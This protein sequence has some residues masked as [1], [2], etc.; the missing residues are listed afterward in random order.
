MINLLLHQSTNS[1]VFA[2]A[3]RESMKAG[4]LKEI[5]KNDTLLNVTKNGE[6][7]ADKILSIACP[8]ECSGHG[9]CKKGII[10]KFLFSDITAEYSVI[11]LKKFQFRKQL[12]KP[13]KRIIPIKLK[14]KNA[15]HI[16][17]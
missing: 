5:A 3:P 17:T 2:A 1:T 10:K 8:G 11:K 14:N 13:L 12:T 15:R 16:S 6:K 7:I 9:V 4:C